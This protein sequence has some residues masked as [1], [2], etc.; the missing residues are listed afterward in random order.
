M[1]ISNPYV[2]VLSMMPQ[3][4]ERF[5]QIKQNNKSK[6]LTEPYPNKVYQDI[7]TIQ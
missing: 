6:F 3:N 2:G 1:G 7:R 5:S 4:T